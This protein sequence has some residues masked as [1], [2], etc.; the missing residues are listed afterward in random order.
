MG[1][2]KSLAV[3]EVGEREREKFEERAMVQGFKYPWTHT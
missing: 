3:G 1:S 2:R